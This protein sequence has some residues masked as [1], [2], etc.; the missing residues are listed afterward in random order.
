MGLF[1]PDIKYSQIKRQLLEIEL[2]KL[3][4]HVRLT[5]GSTISDAD[6]NLVKDAILSHRE[7]GDKIS[8]QHI[9]ETLLHLKSQNRIT[10]Y[11]FATLMKVFE[12]YFIEHFT[13]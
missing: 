9:Y 13:D 5:P 1:G 8:L 11:D 4:A 10:K 6:E 12:K 2:R 3:L 7:S